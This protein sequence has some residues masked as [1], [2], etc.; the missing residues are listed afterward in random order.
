MKMAP[1]MALHVV[2]GR[3]IPIQP[4]STCTYSYTH[5]VGRREITQ[6]LRTNVLYCKNGFY[7]NSCVNT[8]QVL[9]SA[10]FTKSI[11]LSTFD[12]FIERTK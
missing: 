8:V 1:L 12:T 11:R 10:E 4:G 6:N 2:A 9:C 7:G 3:K 5:T